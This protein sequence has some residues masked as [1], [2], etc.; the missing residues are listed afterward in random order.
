M[1]RALEFSSYHLMASRT[2]ERQFLKESM[3]GL[4]W[5]SLCSLPAQYTTE[6]CIFLLEEAIYSF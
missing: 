6:F 4:F 3:L 2:V 5:G 1:Y